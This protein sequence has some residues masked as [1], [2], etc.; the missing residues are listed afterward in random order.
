MLDIVASSILMLL[1]SPLFALA[2]VLVKLSSPGPV[3]FR[4]RRGGLAGRWFEI[5]KFR[6]MTVAK[7]TEDGSFDAGNASRVTAVGAFLRKTKIDELPQLWNVLKGDMSLVGPRPEVEPYLRWY[8]ERWINVLATRP[9]ITDPASVKFR[10]EEEILAAADDPEKEY[11][12]KIL[13]AKLDMYE[14]YVNN[15]SFFNDVKI[16]FATFAAVLFG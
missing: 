1:L 14:D 13:P 3:I 5:M 11:V 2:A 12:E 15:I 4:Q 10:N 8:A 7:G 9:G 6:T 16:L